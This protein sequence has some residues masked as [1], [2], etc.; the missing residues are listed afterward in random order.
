MM[1]YNVRNA[2]GGSVGGILRRTG[3]VS[4][5]GS[6]SGS[7][8]GSTIL[9]NGSGS[10]GGAPGIGGSSS[11]NLDLNHR[12]TPLELLVFGYA[13]K[14]FR[15]DEKAREMDHGKQLIP[16][17]GDVNLKI[18]RY[19]VRGA[20]CELGPHE[21]P[22]GGYGNRLE[23]LSAEE[24]RA[25]QLCEEER[26]LFLYN[27][28]EEL[29]QEE[30]LK[31]LQQET[32]G[33]N[34]SQVGFQYDG[35]SAAA[36]SGSS[37]APS[38][39]SP[40]SEDSELPFVL[41]YTLMMAPPLGM[42]LPDTMKQ[43]AIIE[44]TARFI[45]T[46]GAQMEIL[47]KAKQANN[48]QFD[49][50]TQGGHLQPYYR[51]L[52]AAIKAAKFPPAPETPL[53]QQNPDQE[54]QSTDNLHS[55]DGGADGRRNANQVVITVPTIK[56][57]PSANCAYTQLI[58][59]I[60]GVPLQA[61][62]LEDESSNPEGNSQHSGDTA[63]PTP[64][65][66]SEGHNSQGG[67][68]FTPVLLQY[69][70]STFTHEEEATEQTREQQQPD[71]NGGKPPQVE[72]LKNTSALALAQN[73]SSES[74]EEEEEEEQ[75]VQPEK[76]LKPEPVLTFPVP[77]ESLRHIIDKTATYVIKNGRQF[78]ETLRT[79]SVE[80]FSFLLPANEFYAYY[81]YKVTGDVDA[82][83]K[84]EKTRKAAAVAA[85]LMSKKGL[86][87]GG[88][89]AAAA[90]HNLDKAP[91]SF[92]IRARDEHGPLHPTLPQEAS[93]EEASSIA[94]QL[95][96]EQVRPGMPDSVQRAIKQ[97]ETQL[98]ARTAGQKAG[99]SSISS[100]SSPQKE[101]R[102]AEE[103]VKDKLAQIAREK[104][105]GMISRE[106]QLQLER[107]RKAMAFLNQIKGECATVGS[108]VPGA[109]PNPP[110]PAAG[111]SQ[112]TA[113]D[114][115][116][117]SNESVRSIPITYFGP[118]DDD[119]EQHQKPEVRLDGEK[120]EVEEEE[121]DDDDEDGDGDLE[122]YN[123]LNDDSTNTFT[124]KPV[125]P[126]A[127][128]PPPAPTPAAVLLS[129]D[130]DVQLVA[131]ISSS[132]TSSSRHRKTQ[133]RSRSRSRNERSSASSASSRES[134]HRRRQKSSTTKPSSSL[135]ILARKSQQHHQQLQ[136]MQRRKS[137]K[138][139]RRSMSRSRSRSMRRSRSRSISRT[140]RRSR[141]HSRDR[142]QQ[143]RHTPPTKKSHKR[144][145]RRRRSSSPR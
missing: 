60:K 18:D 47:I 119:D 57:K 2:G 24:Q 32:S 96:A 131:T 52:L 90:G 72:L 88:A 54:S 12:Q 83:S 97:V 73:Y 143:R 93:D 51:H 78:E 1:P 11:S 111:A 130:D 124:S 135:S 134:S 28:E 109:A 118:E 42:Q 69:N 99:G 113:G 138:K 92:S 38:Q 62:L 26:Y 71:A 129:D 19:D 128:P 66:R 30:D 22:P 3:Q 20:L 23:Y 37:T 86:S 127:A 84:E 120:Q 80:R 9:S 7:S 33:G 56:Y 4:G 16:W 136:P 142:Q 98:L 100:S 49:F 41:P 39:L 91:V 58:S 17:M 101:Q 139:R 15:D 70:G 25:E 10:A 21:A 5:S 102:Q 103:R 35:Q 64:S 75:P 50:L 27:N 144:H 121:E 29:R 123:L 115:D 74:E 46:Q 34:Y 137:P 45:A 48:N 141:S 145:K 110:E 82:A 53:D 63:S 125:L 105:N 112:S 116:N 132:R 68:E 6:V 122:K 81:L 8:S 43:H 44:K 140:S 55:E 67:G 107:K 40:T 106:K 94:G 108:A 13:C 65:C 76:E 126:P 36:L 104:L 87:F 89:A 59:K 114:S 79:K 31:R 95:G 85:A 133:R 14:I 77:A 61:V 117:E